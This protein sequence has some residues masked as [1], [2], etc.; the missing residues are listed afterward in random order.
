MLSK[1]KREEQMSTYEYS[2]G[3]AVF[4]FTEGALRRCSVETLILHYRYT[5]VS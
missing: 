1:D 3:E 5:N 2:D 4:E